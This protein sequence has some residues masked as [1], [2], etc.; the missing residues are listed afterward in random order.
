MIQS[1]VFP[2]DTPD[3]PLTE[4]SDCVFI[5]EGILEGTPEGTLEGGEDG[6]P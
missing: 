4:L 6:T 2:S 1:E 3:Q 5:P